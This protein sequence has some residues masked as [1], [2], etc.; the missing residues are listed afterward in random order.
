MSKRKYYGETAT[1]QNSSEKGV[2]YCLWCLFKSSCVIYTV[3]VLLLALL[4]SAIATG[5]DEGIVFFFDLVML[6]PL[7]FVIACAN[8][9]LFKNKT[10]NFWARFALHALIVLS[11][12]VIYLLTVKQYEMNSIVTLMPAFIVMY[13]IFMAVVLWL[14]H[15]KKKHEKENA[16]YADV[17]A[18]VKSNIR[19][20]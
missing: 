15:L 2:G 16:D 20:K 4:V 13:V 19:G 5:E 9:L 6:Y 17:Y 10:M 3:A 1:N 12:A 8:M 14:R 11:S 18:N 7:A